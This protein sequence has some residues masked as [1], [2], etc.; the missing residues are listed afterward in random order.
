VRV[1]VRVSSPGARSAAERIETITLERI[2][3]PPPPK[4]SAV[5]AVRHGSRVDVSWRTDRNASPGA[6]LVVG[7]STRSTLELDDFVPGEAKRAGPR[8]FTAR[9]TGAKS[10]RFVFVFVASDSSIAAPVIVR[11]R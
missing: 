5:K 4:V 6:F 9:L 7:S 1:R 10:V 8:L 3:V 11:V 2:R